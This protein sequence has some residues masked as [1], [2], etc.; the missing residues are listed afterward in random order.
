MA[1]SECLL[2]KMSSKN[3]S[4]KRLLIESDVYIDVHKAIRRLNPSPIARRSMQSHLV[5]KDQLSD[6]VGSAAANAVAG[7][8]ATIPEDSKVDDHTEGELQ[9]E[10]S[11]GERP[12]QR[13]RSTGD[14]PE[15]KRDGKAPT[16]IKRKLSGKDG[17][18]PEM[19]SHL[20]HLG[21][22]NRASAPRTTTSKNIKIKP[23]TTEAQVKK[24]VQ[25]SSPANAGNAK[26]VSFAD[27][28]DGPKPSQAAH[29]QPD[30]QPLQPDDKENE[31]KSYGSTYKSDKKSSDKQSS[32]Q[33][34][35]EI[36]VGTRVRTGSVV[37]RSYEVDGV[38]KVIVEAGSSSS[39]TEGDDIA[40]AA[41]A[42]VINGDSDKKKK[43]KKNKKKRNGN[44]NEE[45][46]QETNES[47]S[48]LGKKK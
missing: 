34:P 27:S 13:R 42:A 33:S 14:M 16:P 9:I 1:L 37:E 19:V 41:A 29:T 36:Y 17:F 6:R 32:T 47:T 11:T 2:L 22:S 48:L 4:A 15:G 45:D 39:D 18:T 31:S 46:E 20:K 24:E 7:V 23:G 30:T 40:A 44:I 43:K 12:D 8:I 5:P 25:D 26:Q 35:S 38:R 3:S 10:T 28:S 21:P